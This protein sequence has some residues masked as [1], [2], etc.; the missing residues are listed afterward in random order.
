M[1]LNGTPV[2]GERPVSRWPEVLG[3]VQ[4]A[5]EVGFDEVRCHLHTPLG[6]DRADTVRAMADVVRAVHG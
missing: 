2:G 4:A 1:E 3:Q 6:S 5:E